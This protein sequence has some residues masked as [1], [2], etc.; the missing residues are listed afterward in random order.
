MGFIAT[1]SSLFVM[2][3]LALG[4]QQVSWVARS[5]RRQVGTVGLGGALAF[6][7]FA[8]LPPD[9]LIG[10]FAQLVSTDPTG[11]GRAQL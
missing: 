3:S 7:G 10:R 2:G 9:K 11:E 8:F 6:S 5:W 4:T 1:L